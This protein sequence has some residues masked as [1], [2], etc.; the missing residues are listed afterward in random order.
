MA[1]IA[2][3]ITAKQERKRLPPTA[4]T[5]RELYLYS[6]NKCAFT[7]CKASLL[8]NDSTWNCNIAHI[9]AVE[10][11]W[12][13]GDHQ[14]SDEDLRKSSNLLLLCTK[15]HKVI[16]NPKLEDGYT[17]EVVQQMKREHERKYREAIADLERIDDLSAS[18]E[19]Q[20]PIN[21]QA[22]EGSFGTQDEVP[23]SLIAMRPW[24]EA[25]TSQP[26]AIR[27]LILICLA[28]GKIDERGTR[29]VRVKT[30]QIEGSVSCSS[31]EISRYAKHLE[32]DGLLSIYED[33]N[34]WFFELIDPTSDEFG[35]D[36]FCELYNLAKKD[37]AILNRAIID[38]DF[39]VFDG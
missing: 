25:I 17:V 26:K 23:G 22:L 13:R 11:N 35:W 7:G 36:M 5:K 38:L 21:M 6:G 32:D 33:D 31:E 27:D 34:I 14:L 16:D 1:I 18:E 19:A 10:V 29:R 4:E 12:P 15:H 2:P 24:I 37:R 3:M 8:L 28:H 39:T 30:T 20:L 9:Y